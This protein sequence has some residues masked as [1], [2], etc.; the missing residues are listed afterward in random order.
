MRME[1]NKLQFYLFFCFTYSFVYNY[2]IDNIF[3]MQN[4]KELFIITFVFDTIIRVS[5]T[6]LYS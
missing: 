4:Y 5:N 3:Q 2:L 1:I 6:I